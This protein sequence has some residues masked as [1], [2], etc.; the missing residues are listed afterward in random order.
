MQGRGQGG[1]AGDEIA[2]QGDHGV[3]RIDIGAQVVV[4]GDGVGLGLGEQRVRGVPLGGLRLGRGGPAAAR[5][6]GPARTGVAGE[7][8]VDLTGAQQLAE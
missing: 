4:G 7:R 1:A 2:A 3:Q 8:G 5:G 6:A